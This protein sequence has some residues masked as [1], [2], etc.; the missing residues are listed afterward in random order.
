MKVENKSVRQ[1]ENPD[2]LDCCVVHVFETYLLFIPSREAN[3]YFRPLP[4]DAA[5]TVKFAVEVGRSTLAKLIPNMCKAAGI[6]GY[7]TGHSGEVT[8]ATTLYR[9]GFSDQL[10]KERTGHRSLKALHQYKRTGS[11]QQHQLSLALGP[12]SMK[13]NRPPP[14]LCDDDDFEPLKKRPKAMS[15]VDMQGMLPQSSMDNCTFNI[16]IQK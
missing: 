10:I 15:A 4:N 8:C 2:D 12:P 16:T 14:S 3:F 13:E 5:G 6:Q 1:Y 11:N 7:K 9:K